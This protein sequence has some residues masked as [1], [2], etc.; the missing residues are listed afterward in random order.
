MKL[1]FRYRVGTCSGFPKS[2]SFG[3]RL[4]PLREQF[5][6]LVVLTTILSSCA[7]N[8]TPTLVPLAATE[9][10]P[11][12][13][14]TAAPERESSMLKAGQSYGDSADD[15][16]ASYLDV[17]S[18]QATV[19]EESETLEVVLHMRDIPSTVKIRQIKNFAE[20]MLDID[21][22]QDPAKITR[23]NAQP[24]YD[25]FLSTYY[26]D[27]TPSEE[28]QTPMPG[29]PVDI[30]IN[31]IWDEKMIHN[32]AGEIIS[33]LEVAADP[34]SDTFTF[35]GHVPGIK[36]SAVFNFSTFCFDGTIDRPDN[37]TLSEANSE[38]TPLPENTPVLSTLSA[39]LA[40]DAERQLTQAGTVH[41]YPGPEHYAGDVLTFEIAA[42]GNFDESVPVT[43]TLDGLNPRV[44][45]GRASFRGLSLPLA[46]DTKNLETGRHSL[47][48]STTDGDLDQTYMFDLLPAGQRP[49]NEEDPT[50]M[51]SEIECC[52]L[53]YISGTAAARDNDFIAEHFQEAGKEISQLTGKNIDPEL[54]V[55]V[56]DR[57]WGNGGFGGE[58]EIVVSY[59]DRYYGPTIGADGLETLARHELTHAAGVGEVQSGDGVLFNAEGLAV[60]VAGGHYKPE[61]L[62]QRGAALF[63]LG[64]YVPIGQSINQHE[65]S[66]LYSAVMLTYIAET[67]E[68]EKMWQFLTTDENPQD[69][70]PT[71]LE[72]EI[73][74]TLGTSPEQFDQDFQ[75]WLETKEP[76]GQLDDL[77][78]TIQLQDLRR[79]YQDT[80]APPPNFIL[81]KVADA[82]A[83]PE[84]LPVMIREARAD[85]NVAV[86]L[87]IAE[88][89]QAIIDR[90]YS[91]A[92]DLNQILD[93]V[94]TSGSFEN[95]L[96]KD[97]LDIVSALAE[98]GYEVVSLNLQ[99]GQAT[100]QVTREPPVVT[101]LELD[102][103]NGIWQVKP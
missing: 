30:P 86:E 1:N 39:P 60:Y 103:N 96:A 32:S 89:Q 82:V 22:F 44:V 6:V 14:A 68:S 78:L 77:R 34:D 54:D 62:A 88:A 101:T 38:S 100:A 17:I 21:I 53:H 70:Q 23:P 51:V 59:T 74:N 98:A 67:Y 37:Y 75:A 64:Y 46:L 91:R 18:F 99:A 11:T 72:A 69:G 5:C 41:A 79:Q 13:T 48:F 90:D 81:A 80:Y 10:Q 29:E 20:H 31:E 55:Y 65:L 3:K 71:S 102:K 33:S 52:I 43:L 27:D 93:Q 47:H 28:I 49:E 16:T 58:G 7:P 56:I 36:S 19:N 76:G 45:S 50:W 87:I 94:I 2:N 61:P 8:P 85:T 24:D 73:Q 57:M 40:I 9:P 66:Y 25:F 63:D 4:V 42:D 12:H 95:G 15:M 26:G 92:E 97:Y 84:Y 83:R 35:T